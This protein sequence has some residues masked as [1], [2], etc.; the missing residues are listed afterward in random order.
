MLK[1]NTAWNPRLK[2]TFLEIPGW[3]IEPGTLKITNCNHPSNYQLGSTPLNFSDQML[4]LSSVESCQYL[5]GWPPLVIFRV[6]GSIPHP[7]VVTFLLYLGQKVSSWNYKPFFI[8]Y[9]RI[10]NGLIL[11]VHNLRISPKNTPKTMK[12]SFLGSNRVWTRD[13]QVMGPACYK[14]AMETC[15]SW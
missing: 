11:K 10:C 14:R 8:Q 13:L 4:K 3:G 2:G 15:C 5:D 12:K 1:I 7:T 6:P 9:H